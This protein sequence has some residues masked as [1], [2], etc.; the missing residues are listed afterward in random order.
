MPVN[1]RAARLAVRGRLLSL[2]AV[3]TTGATTLTATATGFTR[4]TGSFVADG[5]L[6]GMEIYPMGFTGT[7]PGVI[8]GQVSDLS[9]A[10]SGMRVAEAAGGLR[11]LSVTLPDAAHQAWENVEFDPEDK[12]W[13][14]EEEYLPG[15]SPAFMA[16]SS[17][18][19]LCTSSGCTACRGWARMRW[20]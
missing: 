13:F 7:E 10:V 19:N 4:A 1:H 6:T 17:T 2:P 8:E 3:V 5:F 18:R 16:G 9:I 15:G 11:L 20:T 14:I 12:R